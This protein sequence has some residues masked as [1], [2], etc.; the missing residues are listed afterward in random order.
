M[1]ALVRAK[2]IISPPHSPLDVTT[3]GNAMSSRSS[4]QDSVCSISSITPDE[5]STS[6]S[7]FSLERSEFCNKMTW[8]SVNNNNILNLNTELENS[9]KC[10][11]VSYQVDSDYPKWLFAESFQKTKAKKCDDSNLL[12]VQ[13]RLTKSYTEVSWNL[14]KDPE[15][16]PDKHRSLTCS[17]VRFSIGEEILSHSK[18]SIGNSIN[19]EQPITRFYTRFS[20]HSSSDSDDERQNLR[21]VF[22]CDNLQ[23][24]KCS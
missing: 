23:R 22:F 18:C 17:P 3:P 9:S 11:K 16:L 8:D 12:K 21:K 6:S 10:S 7:N 14:H 5:N 2:S 20:K 19:Q 15:V 13:T 24:Q 1:N 4:D